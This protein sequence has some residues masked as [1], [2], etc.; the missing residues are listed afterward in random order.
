MNPDKAIRLVLAP[1]D[2]NQVEII[3]P[4][5][6]KGGVWAFPE[7]FHIEIKGTLLVTCSQGHQWGIYRPWNEDHDD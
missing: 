2:S 1:P 5:C 3:C 6:G 7:G 4:E